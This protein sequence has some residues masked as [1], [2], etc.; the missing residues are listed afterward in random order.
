MLAP[1]SPVPRVP[2]KVPPPPP[3]RRER[4][5]EEAMEPVDFIFIIGLPKSWDS[6]CRKGLAVAVPDG[7]EP[8]GSEAGTVVDGGLTT[9][10]DDVLDED[11]DD[12]RE[13]MGPL[14]SWGGRE[15]NTTSGS[16]EEGRGVAAGLLWPPPPSSATP[17]GKSGV[18]RRD[19]QDPATS[20]R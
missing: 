17:S 5:V 7:L 19:P 4:W 3:P 10:I 8:D 1:N 12:T 20:A 14:D 13:E 2:R 18:V 16:S 6:E 9:M 15:G 11:G